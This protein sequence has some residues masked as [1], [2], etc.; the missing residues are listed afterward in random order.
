M[1]ITVTIVCVSIDFWKYSEAKSLEGLKQYK[2]TMTAIPPTRSYLGLSL[3]L[4][5][6]SGIIFIGSLLSLSD[7]V[8]VIPIHW[9]LA[10]GVLYAIGFLQLILLRTLLQKV[11]YSVHASMV[12][13]LIAVVLSG[14]VWASLLVKFGLD[15]R[16]LPLIANT[17]IDFVLF[18]CLFEV[19]RAGGIKQAFLVS[20]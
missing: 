20:E 11:K 4:Q 9:V 5:V 8:S 15:W 19:Q 13:A 7:I 18:W 2:N 6:V 14:L 10:F 3:R 1:D 12:I 16:I 17:T